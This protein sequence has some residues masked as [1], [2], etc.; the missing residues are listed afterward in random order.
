MIEQPKI[1]SIESYDFG[2]VEVNTEKRG[3]ISIQNPS[4]HPLLISFFIAPSNFLD[5][6]FHELMNEESLI[7]W[8]VLCEKVTLY[9]PYGRKMCQ[10]FLKVN[11]LTEEKLR[12]VIDFFF[13]NYFNMV[14][15]N[16]IEEDLFINFI[17]EQQNILK[18]TIKNITDSTK[19]MKPELKEKC[20]GNCGEESN[21]FSFFS[22]VSI[23]IKP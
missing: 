23:P 5:M 11:L 9:N 4:Q 3:S 17:A 21:L 16:D 10:E 2:K 22:K 19:A 15:N 1:I 12:E 18:N 6:I 8:M 13:K 14:D 20:L 7:K